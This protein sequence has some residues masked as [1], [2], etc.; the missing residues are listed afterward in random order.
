METQVT[1]L[2]SQFAAVPTKRQ[3]LEERDA[4]DLQV[5]HLH[6]TF[7]VRLEEKRSVQFGGS[8]APVQFGGS[9]APVQISNFH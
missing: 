8:S 3:P 9:S 4:E 6:Q 5:S 1:Y 7:I 2:V